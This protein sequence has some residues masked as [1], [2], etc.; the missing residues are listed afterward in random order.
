MVIIVIS[1][2]SLFK[3]NLLCRLNLKVLS[4]VQLC[5]CHMKL[6]CKLRNLSSGITDH[7]MHNHKSGDLGQGVARLK[8]QKSVC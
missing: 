4:A 1:S 7:M 2:S 3:T 5:K 6:I 8:S